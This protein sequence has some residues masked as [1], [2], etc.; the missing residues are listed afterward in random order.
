M[1]LRFRRSKKIAP[2]VRFN[3]NKKS[4]SLTFGGKGFHKTFSTNGKKT[5]SVGLPGTGLYYT[6]TSGGGKSMNKENNKNSGSCLLTCLKWFLILLFIIPFGWV[7]GIIWF[8][9]FR[10]NCDESKRQTY[11]I[12]IAILS[13]LSLGCMTYGL[14]SPSDNKNSN[15]E[16]VSSQKETESQIEDS[17]TEIIEETQVQ[18]NQTQEIVSENTEPSSP[19]DN[20]QS[21]Q[22]NG[23]SQESAQETVQEPIQ[24]PTTV[25]EEHEEPA[26]TTTYILNTNTMKIHKTY[27]S[28][29]KDIKA[30][31]YKETESTIEE[32]ESQGYD[33]C[34]RCF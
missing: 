18:E 5:T 21:E 2:G 22:T 7:A 14:L 20:A 8:L 1:G 33:T 19:V 32:L 26:Q 29:A 12:I 30:E 17:E 4:A 9:F 27:C 24:E 13:V 23:S 3:L 34:K 31:N 16:V 6:K 15:T 11:S 28:S 10:K 25:S